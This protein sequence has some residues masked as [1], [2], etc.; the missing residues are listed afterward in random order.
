[1]VEIAEFLTKLKESIEHHARELRRGDL[2]LPEYLTRNAFTKGVFPKIADALASALDLEIAR[3]HRNYMPPPKEYECGTYQRVDYVLGQSSAPKFFLELES[4]DRSQLYTFWDGE[5]SDAD[6][7]NKLWY[8]YGTLVNHYT[9]ER[10]APRFFVWLLILPDRQVERYQ[11]WDVAPA[12]KLFHRSLR[13]LVFKNPHRFYDHLIKS[14]ARLFITQH[15]D[16]KLPGATNWT[17]KSLTEFQDV[18]ELV[19]ITCTGERLL[20]SRGKDLF[21][22]EKEKSVALNWRDRASGA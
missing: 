18:C 19:F 1:M 9:Y 14:A 8:Y 7:D 15:H 21:D 16:F 2:F 3:E 5:A 22:P 20:L 17:K 11:L 6:N 4:L 12:Y 13:K 10:R